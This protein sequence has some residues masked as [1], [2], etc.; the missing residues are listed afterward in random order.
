MSSSKSDSSAGSMTT[1]LMV[2]SMVPAADRAAL[3][4]AS[5]IERP[6]SDAL[7]AALIVESPTVT[8]E[9]GGELKF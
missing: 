4:V 8:G 1:S 7:R 3:N 9:L 6:T 5:P 2:D